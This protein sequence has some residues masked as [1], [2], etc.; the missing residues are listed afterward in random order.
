M[1]GINSLCINQGDQSKVI[2]VGQERS[3]TYWDMRKAQPE[4]VL[5]SSP[6]PNESDELFCI[7]ISN[8]GRYFVTGGSLGIVRL[9]EYTTGRCVSEQKG[10][11]HAIACVRFSPDG[12]QII[13]TG[14]DGLVL[15]WNVFM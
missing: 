12:K 9:W 14:L 6:N 5:A 2:T 7:A 3:I 13:S 4:A 15:V 1:G 10:H 11:S 8:D